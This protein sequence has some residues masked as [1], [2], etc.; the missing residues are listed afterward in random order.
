[1]QSEEE[2]REGK[3]WLLMMPSSSEAYLVGVDH[4]CRKGCSG[5][6]QDLTVELHLM[7][8]Q[9]VLHIGRDGLCVCCTATTTYKHLQRHTVSFSIM[10]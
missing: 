4:L 10:C 6:H 5:L 1:M 2:T 8:V 3:A 9:V 7:L